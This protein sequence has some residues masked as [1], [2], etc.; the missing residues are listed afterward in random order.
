MMF[1]KS[2][3]ERHQISNCH[4]S[5]HPQSSRQDK[6]RT[7][8][9]LLRNKGRSPCSAGGGRLS[10]ITP[11]FS[12]VDAPDL[13]RVSVRRVLVLLTTLSG[14]MTSTTPSHRKKLKVPPR[15]TYTTPGVC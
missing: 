11:H 10:A 4:L 5:G 3:S 12:R 9:S 7:A 14:P 13:E 1:L 2:E 8:P 6:Q 15:C